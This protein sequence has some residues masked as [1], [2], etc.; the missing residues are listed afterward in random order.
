MKDHLRHIYVRKLI[1]SHGGVPAYLVVRKMRRSRNGKKKIIIVI[2][3]AVAAI[4]LFAAGLQ[5][6]ERMGFKDV[7]FGDTGEW[8][9]GEVETTEI[10]LNDK[11]YVTKDNINTYLIIGT[12]SGGEDLGEM[13]SGEL[14]DFLTVLLV[15]NTTQKFAFLQIDRNSMVEMVVPDEEGNTG[16]I[17]KMQVCI[18]HWYGKTLNERNENT[19]AA[20]TTLLGDLDIDNVYSIEM[21]D[22]GAINHAIGGVEVDIQTDMTKVDPEFVKGNHILLSDEQANK[23]VRARTGVGS[24]TNAERMDRQTS[25]C[26]KHTTWL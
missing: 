17:T 14:A 6:A 1:G 2:I 9:N 4:L 22:I 18:S 7:Q 12:D 15:D 21:K 10:G 19:A 26:K 13:Y 20:V 11:L 24:G 8:G 23:F 5:I 3:A 25:T 16:A